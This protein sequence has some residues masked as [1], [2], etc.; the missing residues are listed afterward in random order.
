[1]TGHSDRPRRGMGTIALY[2]VVGLIL[3]FLI[4]P[5]F[6]IFP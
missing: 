3:L 5:I 2:I 4:L 1:M 6:I